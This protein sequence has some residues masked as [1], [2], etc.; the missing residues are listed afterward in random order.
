MENFIPACNLVLVSIGNWC[1]EVCVV[2]VICW[3]R[4]VCVFLL[5]CFFVIILSFFLVIVLRL[6]TVVGIVCD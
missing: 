6:S 5:E 2:T 3:M 4:V 1:E